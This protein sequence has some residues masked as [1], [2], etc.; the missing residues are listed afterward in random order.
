[1]MNIY[2]EYW[3][4]AEEHL[5]CGE[6]AKERYDRMAGIKKDV[7]FYASDKTEEIVKWRYNDNSK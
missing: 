1:M 2:E 7:P 5:I 3:Y 4:R 6:T